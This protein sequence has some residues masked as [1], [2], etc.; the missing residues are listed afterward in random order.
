MRRVARLALAPLL[1]LAACGG[2]DAP[3][4]APTAP[5]RLPSSFNVQSCLDQPVAPGATVANL[6]APDTIK[7]DLTRPAGFPNGRRLSDPVIDLIL[8]YIFVDVPRQG[9]DALVKLPL[10]PAANDRPFR[11]EF[12]YMAAPQGSPPGLEPGGANFNFRTDPVSA[13]VQVDR[14]GMPAV[15]TALISSSAKSTYNDDNPAI[16]GTR[17]YVTEIQNTLTALTNVLADD[18]TR[19]GIPLCAKGA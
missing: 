13:Y 18:F 19:L 6:V 3:L 7:V 14:M 2:D 16:D 4:P 11:A 17:K 10:N 5:E 8:A 15:A 1:L 9:V 12:P